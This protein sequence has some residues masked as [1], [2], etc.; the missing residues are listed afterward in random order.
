M[1]LKFEIASD[2]V[3]AKNKTTQSGEH[4]IS[5]AQDGFLFVEGQKYPTPVVI[6]IPRDGT[7]YAVGFY[8][9]DQNS[10]YVNRYARL[11]VFPRL[12]PMQKA[13]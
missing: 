8:T 6:D 12:V 2:E 3:R 9:L 1:Q 10:F 4:Y 11:D 7:P 5:R 13:A